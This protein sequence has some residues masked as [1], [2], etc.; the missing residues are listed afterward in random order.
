MKRKDI[1]RALKKA[2]WIIYHGG[3]HDM[4]VHPDHP[5]KKIPLPRHKEVKEITAK[6]ILKDAGLK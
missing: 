1:D 6:S 5:D 2:G 4:A 3:S